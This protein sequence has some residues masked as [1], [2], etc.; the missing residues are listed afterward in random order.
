MQT[1]NKQPSELNAALLASLSQEDAQNYSI[2]DMLNPEYAE[3]KIRHSAT[4]GGW[5]GNIHSWR[6][7]RE[8]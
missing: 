4:G 8:N 6:F 5:S 1:N 7:G 3:K 2:G